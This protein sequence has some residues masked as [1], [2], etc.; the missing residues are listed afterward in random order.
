MPNNLLMVLTLYLTID[1]Y[2]LYY[3]KIS[4]TT[5]FISAI[6]SIYFLI[7]IVSKISVYFILKLLTTAMVKLTL[8]LSNNI[9]KTMQEYK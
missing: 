3:K 4:L 1:I 8:S 2:F 5:I 6:Q 9:S 7:K